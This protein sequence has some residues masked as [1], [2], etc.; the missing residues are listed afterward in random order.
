MLRTVTAKMGVMVHAFNPS[1]GEAQA[2][3]S[4]NSRPAWFTK[5]GYT[6]KP[7]LENPNKK[8]KKERERK[9][10]RERDRKK[11]KKEGR[12][13]GRKKEGG[14]KEQMNSDWYVKNAK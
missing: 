8:R 5:Q 7:C 11:G 9:R 4:L 3:R 13:T 12:T 6:E 14:R 10:K 1:T 2:G